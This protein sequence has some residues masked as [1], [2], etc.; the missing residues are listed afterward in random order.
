M[1]N[2]ECRTPHLECKMQ[3][4]QNLA[5][6]LGVCVLHTEHVAQNCLCALVQQQRGICEELWQAAQC[7]SMVGERPRQS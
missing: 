2:N 1:Q 6:Q 7:G 4:A 5:G 3:A